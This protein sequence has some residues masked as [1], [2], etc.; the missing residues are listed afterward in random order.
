M[1]RNWGQIKISALII[2][3]SDFAYHYMD[4]ATWF[5]RIGRGMGEATLKIING[6]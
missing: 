3:G 2:T 6:Q 5:N 1:S 4:S